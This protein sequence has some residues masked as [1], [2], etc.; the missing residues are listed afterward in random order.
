MNLE[1]DRKHTSIPFINGNDFV[2]YLLTEKPSLSNIL[3]TE[4]SGSYNGQLFE[5]IS[6]VVGVMKCFMN[7]NLYYY[8]NS[9]IKRG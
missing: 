8:Y 5:I 3:S 2:N 9:N 6:N 4:N 1:M 7:Y